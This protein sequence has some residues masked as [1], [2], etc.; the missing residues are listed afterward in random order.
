MGNIARVFPSSYS[1]FG[2]GRKGS[3]GGRVKSEGPAFLFKER[4]GKF[5]RSTLV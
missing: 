5:G 2:R 1:R 4:D 3:G